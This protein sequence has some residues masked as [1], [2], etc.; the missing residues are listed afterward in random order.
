MFHAVELFY[1][2]M[3]KKKTGS[4]PHTHKLKSLEEKYL[5]LY[6]VDDYKVDHPFRFDDYQPCELNIGELEL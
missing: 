6:L 1:K 3:I 4:V 2:Y 5:K